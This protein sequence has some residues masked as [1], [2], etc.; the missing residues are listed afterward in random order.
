MTDPKQSAATR[1]RAAFDHVAHSTQLYPHS[2]VG[3]LHLRSSQAF[4]KNSQTRHTFYQPSSLADDVMAQSGGYTDFRIV[5]GQILRSAVI[6]ATIRAPASVVG[7]ANLPILAK[8]WYAPIDRVEIYAQGGSLLIQRLDAEALQQGLAYLTPSQYEAYSHTGAGNVMASDLNT[9]IYWPLGPAC[10]FSHHIP[11]AALSAPLTVR[12]Y[13]R[14]AQ[15]W[16][17]GIVPLV[18]SMSLLTA[19]DT[20]CAAENNDLISRWRDPRVHID[21]RFNRQGY[22]RFTETLTPSQRYSF[23]MTSVSGLITS[24]QVG[25]RSVASV[26]PGPTIAPEMVDILDGSGTSI[27]GGSPLPY[28]YLKHLQAV[29]GGEEQNSHGAPWCPISF[30]EGA[31]HAEESGVIHGY[32]AMSNTHQLVIHTPASLV[33]GSYELYIIINRVA[34]LRC[35][36]GNLSILET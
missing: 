4:V 19:Q 1:G 34:T 7:I 29:L 31:R 14:G 5:N 24:L 35:L 21:V 2:K 23:V 12:V 17:N 10:I 15:G 11:V 27:L 3:N 32:T 13:W 18:S 20:I 28:V 8:D 26:L 36:G 33:A 16:L 25:I 22:M 6:T 9:T 30:S